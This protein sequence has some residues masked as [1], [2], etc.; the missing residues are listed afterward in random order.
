MNWRSVADL[1]RLC[2]EQFPRAR[3][4]RADVVVGIPR[5][6][7]LP[8]SL[9]ALAL[10]LPLATVDEFCAGRGARRNH[11][12][13]S[14]RARSVLL[15]D[16]SCNSGKA[17]LNATAA[18]LSARPEV[19][20]TKLAVFAKPESASV[21]DL[22]FDLCNG[23][24]VFQWNMWRHIKLPQFA[25][26]IDGVLCRDPSGHENDDGPRYVK[27]LETVE[28]WYVPKRPVGMLVTCRLEKYRAQTEAWLSRHGITYGALHM[29]DLPDK[30]A[31]LAEQPA[32]SFKSDLYAASDFRLF[33]ESAH[34]KARGI[35][36]RTGRPVL[37]IEGWEMVTC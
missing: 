25:F 14:Q 18:M 5:S 21:L 11:V 19:H 2:A 27:F 33:V 36:K 37:S 4:A 26:D 31:R 3:A 6:G 8:A 24:R 13:S 7:M 22:H 16:D 17:M 15:V 28:P 12:E 35:A 29:L 30:A 20:I 9:M 1:T 32:V 34:K 10:D 23:P